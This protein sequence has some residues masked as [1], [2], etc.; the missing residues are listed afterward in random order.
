MTDLATLGGTFALVN[1]MNNRDQVVGLSNL[2]GD[3]VSHAFLWDRGLLRDL[4]TFGGSA[5]EADWINDAGEVVW[6]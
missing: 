3:L 4:G 5:S 1:A 6:C 2:A